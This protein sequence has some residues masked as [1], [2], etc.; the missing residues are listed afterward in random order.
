MRSSAMFVLAAVLLAQPVPMLEPVLAHGGRTAADGCH[1]DRKNGG[2]HCHNGSGS[3][4]G[5]VLGLAY[6]KVR[7]GGAFVNCSAARAAGAAPVRAGDSGYGRHLDR[8]GD[9]VGCE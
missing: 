7:I 5:A 3:A 2:R 9:G 8:D 1:N 6:P 4:S